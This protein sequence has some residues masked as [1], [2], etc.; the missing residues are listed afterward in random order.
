MRVCPCL[1]VTVFRSKASFTKRSVSSRIACFDISRLFCLSTPLGT[2]LMQP[3]AKSFLP[4]HDWPNSVSVNIHLLR[5]FRRLRKAATK[6]RK[7]VLHMS[8][9]NF[10]GSDRDALL[11]HLFSE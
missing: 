3:G 11:G 1:T 10:L 4:F 8:A 6:G 5:G 2:A 7:K 9:M